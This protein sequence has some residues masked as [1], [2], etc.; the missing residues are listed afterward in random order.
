LIND[1][2]YYQQRKPQLANDIFL[3]LNEATYKKN[4]ANNKYLHDF[5]E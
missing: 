2:G 5:E 1:L 3:L 4:Q